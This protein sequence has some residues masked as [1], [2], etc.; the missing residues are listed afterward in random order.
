VYRGTDIGGF[1]GTYVFGDF[2][3]GR[4]W[5]I[6][7][8]STQGTAPTE[9]LDTGF[10]IASFAEDLDGELYLIDYGSGQIHSIIDG[11]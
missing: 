11:P 3:S 4:I 2:G 9:L 8:T 7:A 10:N 6:D 5:G 1:Q